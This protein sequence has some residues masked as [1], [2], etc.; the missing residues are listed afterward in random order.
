MSILILSN[1]VDITIKIV[2]L[3]NSVIFGGRCELDWLLNHDSEITARM[4]ILSVE[5]CDS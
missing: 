5:L 2:R 3:H 1:I 4:M